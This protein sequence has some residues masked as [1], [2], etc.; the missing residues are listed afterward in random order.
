MNAITANRIVQTPGTCSGEPRIDGTRI[1]VRH[2][3]VWHEFMN[4]SADQI[5]D[6]YGLE[7]SDIYA[8]LAFFHSNR[9]EIMQ[10]MNA[11]KTLVEALKKRFPSQLPVHV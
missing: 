9:A 11:E 8:A 4:M 2:I 1:K 7:L 3:A 10:V 5:A 6:E